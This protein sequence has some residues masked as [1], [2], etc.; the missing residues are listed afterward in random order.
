VGDQI[1]FLSSG[2]KKHAEELRKDIAPAFEEVKNALNDSGTIEGG[3]FSI[4]GTM[5][6]MAYPGALQFAFEDMTTHAKMIEDFADGVET[7]A[8][9]YQGSEDAN[10]LKQV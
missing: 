9:N 6:S 10:T 8:K 1:N 2:I 7:T 5:A 3:D 4:T